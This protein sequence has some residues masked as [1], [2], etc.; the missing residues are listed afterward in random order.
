MTKIKSN[1]E[2]KEGSAVIIEKSRFIN[3]FPKRL[4]NFQSKQ[5][6]GREEKVEASTIKIGTT[7]LDPFDRSN[8]FPGKTIRERIK[9]N[10]RQRERE[11][12]K[13][14]THIAVDSKAKKLQ[15]TLNSTTRKPKSLAVIKNKT[16]KK[17]NKQKPRQGRVGFQIW[18]VEEWLRR[19]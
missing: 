9:E 2:E 4:K 11:R 17:H 13:Q 6:E 18:S 5:N 19:G 7:S 14:F 12:N 1:R 15:D 10:L 3:L 16:E 8:L